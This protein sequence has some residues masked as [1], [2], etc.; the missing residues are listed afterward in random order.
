MVLAWATAASIELFAHGEL[1]VG[2]FHRWRP[3]SAAALGRLICIRRLPRT[4]L[5]PRGCRLVAFVVVV[6]FIGMLAVP[7]SWSRGGGVAGA[8]A[9]SLPG[10]RLQPAVHSGHYRAGGRHFFAIACIS[11]G[12]RRCTAW[13]VSYRAQR[14]LPAG[15]WLGMKFLGVLVA[16]ASG[17]LSRG[18]REMLS[19]RRPC[20]R[21]SA[22]AL[23]HVASVVS[24]NLGGFL[25]RGALGLGGL[26]PNNF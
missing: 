21:W 4:P 26:A 5:R 1:A 8:L 12:S 7:R 20:A 9:H 10:A 25:A 15:I 13:F 24:G 22:Q 16:I 19:F 2:C 3:P 14:A 18:R 6:L 23:A 17:S 11:S